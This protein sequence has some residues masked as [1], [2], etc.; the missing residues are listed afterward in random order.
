M[1]YLSS[2]YD[3]PR[4]NLG[5]NFYPENPYGF[6]TEDDAIYS[7]VSDSVF[8][9]KG[10]FTPRLT[11]QDIL[12]LVAGK[13]AVAT[14][15][16]P[17]YSRE[18]LRNAYRE[19][20]DRFDKQEEELAKVGSELPS[21]GRRKGDKI[22]GEFLFE[23]L[24]RRNPK[25]PYNYHWF[26]A[27][28]TSS[29][30]QQDDLKELGKIKKQLNKEGLSD[31]ESRK[32]KVKRE[33][34]IARAYNPTMD[35]D[36]YHTNQSTIMP[37]GKRYLSPELAMESMY[38]DSGRRAERQAGA[39]YLDRNF[40]INEKLG[41]FDYEKF[42]NDSGYRKEVTDEY[43]KNPRVRESLEEYMKSPLEYEPSFSGRLLPP[44]RGDGSY[45]NPRSN[46]IN[47][48]YHQLIDDIRNEGKYSSEN[49]IS[50]PGTKMSNI[51]DHEYSHLENRYLTNVAQKLLDE[52]SPLSDP[53]G[54]KKEEDDFY[55]KLNEVFP[56][57]RLLEGL[58]KYSKFVNEPFSENPRIKQEEG[59]TLDWLSVLKE[60][61]NPNAI[62]GYPQ[63]YDNTPFPITHTGSAQE[64]L[65]DIKAIQEYMTGNPNYK[66]DYTDPNS[67]FT[68]EMFE[69]LRED[70]NVKDS[71]SLKRI[72]DRYESFSEIE[73]LMNLTSN[74]QST[75]SYMP[76]RRFFPSAGEYSY[77]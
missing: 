25:F 57:M 50:Y 5:L 19:A 71:M 76:N 15:K 55:R 56:Q 69:K 29:V 14:E 68:K 9:E 36:N 37:D 32:L 12:D 64:L 16:Q 21:F 41:K 7:G 31:E 51:L 26:P 67:F 38:R 66:Y 46:I 33:K 20:R 44:K 48:D 28:N 3:P 10:N 4:K 65:A 53:D 11:Q 35:F 6:T 18:D 27:A 63:D 42:K 34:I 17:G 43:L 1:R 61:K 62:L 22:I 74:Q 49:R 59:D 58:S 13:K 70:N 30:L 24:H 54:R 47:L 60:S 39:Y 72:L 23:N 52:Y 75:P 40:P 45:F 8:Y 2:V 73:K 77:S